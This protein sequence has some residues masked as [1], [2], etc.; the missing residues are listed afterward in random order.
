MLKQRSIKTKLL[1]VVAALSVAV[2]LLG[3][4]GFWGL[5]RYRNLASS[6]SIAVEESLQAQ[7]LARIA[8]NLSNG[9]RRIDELDNEGGMI[10][11]DMI[12]LGDFRQMQLTTEITLFQNAQD[13]FQIQLEI[14]ETRPGQFDSPKRLLID[15]TNR[16][17]GIENIR[18]AYD[19]YV[20]YI[21]ASRNEGIDDQIHQNAVKKRLFE[22]TKLC[23]E[24]STSINNGMLQYSEEVHGASRGWIT[25][26]W[27]CFCAATL[28]IAFLFWMFYSRIVVPFKMLLDGSRLYSDKHF[29]TRISL[30]TGD[31]LDELAKS[32]NA[33]YDRFEKKYRESEDLATD[34]ERQVRERSAEV[35]RNEQL[36]SVGF[37]AA[38]VAH[39]INNPLMGMKWAIDAIKED[40]EELPNIDGDFRL[41][42]ELKEESENAL[43][44]IKNEAVRCERITKRLV[45]FSRTSAPIREAISVNSVVDDIVKL[46]SKV[47]QFKSKTIRSIATEDVVA[48]VNIDH[49]QQVILNLVTN[50]LE[51]VGENGTVEVRLRN[52]NGMA[53]ILVEDDGC[54]MTDETKRNLFEPFYTRRKD[55]TGTG[56][57]LS[58]CARIVSQYG[59]TLNPHSDGI[60][61][62]ST[63]D[64][65]L[66]TEPEPSLEQSDSLATTAVPKTPSRHHAQVTAVARAA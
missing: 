64:L 61:R 19:E 56:L 62:G 54:G 39:E 17:T 16:R 37:L 36:A 10:E 48:H 24:H 27:V 53:V 9:F 43:E 42:K 52:E 11:S 12:D 30:D 3:F 1:V 28:A 7:Q 65:R 4:S 2:L 63:M 51:S 5:S 66:P 57:G 20:Q 60:D 29:G 41:S 18:T 8:S 32:F 35:I 21:E 58:I 34:L 47:E 14:A 45:A 26:F 25:I 23:E 31:E 55:G 50:A 33:S 6:L 46:I 22:L 40:L 15:E 59:G 13:R 44:R 49:L 38:G